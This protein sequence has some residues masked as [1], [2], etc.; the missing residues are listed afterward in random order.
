MVLLRHDLLDGSWHYDWMLDLP[1]ADGGAGGGGGLVTF[2]VLERPEAVGVG[3]VIAG[4]RLADHRRAYL[5]YEGEVSGGR[6]R[7]TRLARGRCGLIAAAREQ[8]EFHMDVDGHGPSR[9]RAVRGAT[10]WTLT[11]TA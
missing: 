10:G 4:E 9:W 2:R 7:V 5:T 3:G 11:R 1:G 6:G 8:F